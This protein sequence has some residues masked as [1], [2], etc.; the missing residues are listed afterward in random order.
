[1]AHPVTHFEINA[2]DPAATQGFYRD[3]FGWA[4]TNTPQN[5]GMID[6]KVPAPRI[7]MSVLGNHSIR[8]LAKT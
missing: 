1:M 6:T 7:K 4:V 2:R 3:V 5:Y 8:R